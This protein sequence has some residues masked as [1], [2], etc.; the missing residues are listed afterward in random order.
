MNGSWPKNILIFASCLLFGYFLI[1]LS[2]GSIQYDATISLQGILSALSVFAVSLGI[3]NSYENNKKTEDREKRRVGLQINLWSTF[4]RISNESH[5]YVP[6]TAYI[7]NS[8]SEIIYN[9]FLISTFDNKNEVTVD[10]IIN[11]SF[12]GLKSEEFRH[13]PLLRPGTY[14]ISVNGNGFSA[15]G[16]HSTPILLFRDPVGNYWMR[17]NFGKLLDISKAKWDEIMFKLALNGPFGSETWLKYE[18]DKK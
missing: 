18:G 16:T 7:E 11:S 17:N 13:T 3:L 4:E 2:S 14:R 6:Y 8:S 10:N 9:V 15:G 12:L 5:I 1:G